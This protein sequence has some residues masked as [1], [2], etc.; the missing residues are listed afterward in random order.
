MFEHRTAR[1]VP[2]GGMSQSLFEYVR[3]QEVPHG[4]HG[5]GLSYLDTIT[6]H[7]RHLIIYM[8]VHFL[9]YL[10]GDEKDRLTTML[11][12]VWIVM[13][14]SEDEIKIPARS[15]RLQYDCSACRIPDGLMRS[16]SPQA[17]WTAP[18]TVAAYSWWLRPCGRRGT[19][20][21]VDLH[22]LVLVLVLYPT[23]SIEHRTH[24]ATQA[25]RDDSQ[26]T[27]LTLSVL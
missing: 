19:L 6:D 17:G 23:H 2:C 24:E 3:R 16:G 5:L 27:T 14:P 1:L 18:S 21:G 7:L 10:P 4:R 8:V 13:E 20:A 15:M 12:Y 9:V 25:N 22:R 11:G 26:S